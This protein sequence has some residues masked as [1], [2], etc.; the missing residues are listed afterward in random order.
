VRDLFIRV[1][2]ELAPAHLRE[3]FEAYIALSLREEI[4]RIPAYYAPSR[5]ASFWVAVDGRGLAGNFGLEPVATG[6]ELR[7]MYVDPR[8]RR[9]GLGRRMLAHAER[10]AREQGHARMVLSTSEL[11]QAALRLYRSAG[12]RLVREEVA[13]AATNRTVGSGLRRFYFEKQIGGDAVGTP[14]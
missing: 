8:Y 3:P 4:D 10:V 13:T 2:R 9:K 14:R 11:Q 12:Y 7:R 6:L 1:N 5:G